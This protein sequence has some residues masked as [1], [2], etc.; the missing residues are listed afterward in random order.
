MRESGSSTNIMGKEL[1]Q[2]QMDQF[3]KV[4]LSKENEMAMELSQCQTDRVIVGTGRKICSTEKEFINGLMDANILALL[5][6]TKCMGR[7]FLNL[8]M[9]ELTKVILD[10][11]IEKDKERTFG[12]MEQNTLEIGKPTSKREKEKSHSQMVNHEKVFGKMENE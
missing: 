7:D 12:Q 10:L 6:I 4:G 8:G 3:T 1:K 5:K 11:I 2:L 9:E